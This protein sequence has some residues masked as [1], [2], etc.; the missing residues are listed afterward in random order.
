LAVNLRTSLK[1]S[2]MRLRYAVAAP[3]RTAGTPRYRGERTAAG[4]EALLSKADFVLERIT[5][6]G[7]GWSVK[8]QT[9]SKMPIIA[10][11]SCSRLWQW[12]TNLP[13]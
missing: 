3:W 13:G 2:S 4:Y 12:Y 8:P 5:P 1:A 11:S 7:E 9:T 10:M 6:V